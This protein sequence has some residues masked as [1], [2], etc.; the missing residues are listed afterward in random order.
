MQDREVTAAEYLGFLNAPETR[1]AMDAAARPLLVPRHDTDPPLWPRGTDGVF[2][3]PDGT[4]PDHPVLGVSFEDA[5]AY[6]AWRSARAS[7]A[8]EPWRWRLPLQGEWSEAAGSGVG[9]R[10]PFGP[11][12]RPSWASSNFRRPYPA[13]EPVLSHPVDESA[14]GVFDMCGSAMEWVED[15]YDEPRGLRRLRGG[16]W[17]QGW[18]E[19]LAV[20]APR[21]ARP[22]RAD[23][24]FGFRLVGER[25]AAEAR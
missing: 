11:R 23:R 19:A 10:F 5:R 17:A 25:A 15:W 6:A 13:P 9:R 2:R 7:A 16:S 14:Y 20:W 1:V 18:P 21:G 12:F 8:G 3:L 4:A 24:E 22:D